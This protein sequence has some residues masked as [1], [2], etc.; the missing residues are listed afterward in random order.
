MKLLPTAIFLLAFSSAAAEPGFVDL[1][2]GRTLNGWVLIEGKGP[3]YVVKDGRIVCP[4]DGG[5]NLYTE[6]AY[7]DFILRFEFRLSPGGNNGIGIRA[8]LAKGNASYNG[9]E[10]QVLDHYDP[11][12]CCWLKPTQ[13]HG[14]IYGLVPARHGFLNRAGEWNEQ[15]IAAIG[16][17]IIVKL[18]GGV[19]VDANLD[20]IRDPELLKR[21][22]GIARTSGHIGLLGHDS[23]VE[24]RN[25]RIKDLSQR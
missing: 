12:Y 7:S 6:K 20:D 1:F 15:E 17:R 9:L 16:R 25:L 13:Y 19:I 18:N 8:P 24:F 3:G 22:P 11:M 5:G 4:A 21:H 14:S 2:D 10:I 23:Y